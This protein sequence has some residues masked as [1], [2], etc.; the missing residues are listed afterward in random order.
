MHVEP[1]Q[2]IEPDACEPRSDAQFVVASYILYVLRRLQLDATEYQVIKLSACEY[3]AT[4]HYWL[5]KILPYFSTAFAFHTRTGDSID[6]SMLDLIG[7]PSVALPDDICA[8]TDC[9]SIPR[10]PTPHR[11]ATIRVDERGRESAKCTINATM[12]GKKK[13]T[14]TTTAVTNDPD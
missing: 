9:C 10:T 6:R 12:R 4:I 2:D 1:E 3:T 7:T 8:K 14:T 11:R 5:G 13:T